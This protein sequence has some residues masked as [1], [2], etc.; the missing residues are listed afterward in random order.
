[1]ID[2]W[3]RDLRE[4]IRTSEH[5]DRH[6]KLTPREKGQI[7]QVIEKHPMR[8]THHYLSLVDKNDPADPIRKMVV[9]SAEE[10]N[11]LAR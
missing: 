10:F 9:P 11:L 4:S 5:L 1:M 3:K 2:D 7:S 6:L 8:I